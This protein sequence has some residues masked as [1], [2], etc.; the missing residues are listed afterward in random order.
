MVYASVE[1]LRRLSRAFRGLSVSFVKEKILNFADP[2]LKER[3]S[4]KKPKKGSS[5]K[6]HSV[7]TE[8]RKVDFR[9][10]W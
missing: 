4:K 7:P 2:M 5:N 10:Q 1:Y 6:L 3:P 8:L 9:S